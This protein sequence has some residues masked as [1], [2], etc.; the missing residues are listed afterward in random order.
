MTVETLQ[1]FN[2]IRTNEEALV[3]QMQSGDPLDR[4]SVLD[5]VWQVTQ[6]TRGLGQ[7]TFDE[8]ISSRGR[9]VY[10]PP[11]HEEMRQFELGLIEQL[12]SQDE[13]ERN[14]AEA[15]LSGFTAW[16]PGRIFVDTL[17]ALDDPDILVQ[18]EA[19]W[20]LS[21]IGIRVTVRAL[22][23]AIETRG[24][25]DPRIR[26]NIAYA[27]G[28]VHIPEAIE[29]LQTLLHD[30]NE[31]VR[32]A[33]LT[34]IGQLYAQFGGEAREEFGRVVMGPKEG[35]VQPDVVEGLQKSSA[36][37]QLQAAITIAEIQNPGVIEKLR[38]TIIHGELIPLQLQE[39][40]L[41]VGT[42]HADAARDQFQKLTKMLGGIV[43]ADEL[44]EM[45]DVGAIVDVGKGRLMRIHSMVAEVVHS[46]NRKFLESLDLPPTN[47]PILCAFTSNVDSLCFLDSQVAQKIIDQAIADAIEEGANLGRSQDD[48]IAEIL[49]IAHE[50]NP[51]NVPGK[52]STRAHVIGCVLRMFTHSGSKKSIVDREDSPGS[53][54]RLAEWIGQTFHPVRDK[55]G[56]ASAQMADFL[57]GIGEG[58]VAVY[59]QY[60]SPIQAAA[61]RNRRTKFFRQADGASFV[62]DFVSGESSVR[63]TDPTKIN[64]PIER[65]PGVKVSVNGDT[66]EAGEDADREIIT[67]DYYDQDGHAIDFEPLFFF[68]PPV[69]EEVGR[70]MRYFIINGPH[71]LQ[72]YKKDKYDR[73]APRLHT[74]LQTLQQEGVKIHF[75]FSG[76]T[77]R[78]TG[79]GEWT[80]IRYFKDVLRGTV[81][82]MGINHTELRDVVRS[83]HDDLDPAIE[84]T[85]EESPYALYR[86]AVALATYLGLDRLH[87]HGHSIDI[88]LRRNTSVEGLKKEQHATFHAKQRVGEWLLGQKSQYPTPKKR[89]QSPLLKR[90]GFVDLMKL[91]EQLA[92]A[93]GLEGVDKIRYMRDVAV[94]G[95]EFPK[96]EGYSAVIMPGKWIYVPVEVTTSAGDTISAAAFAQSGL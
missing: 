42:L 35:I 95:F 15:T 53:G 68:T 73:I 77:G 86:N 88:T 12:H 58:N 94:N 57:T 3:T 71:Y 5:I 41:G 85:A 54:K 24:K 90:E 20:A 40:I 61:Y 63:S 84:A 34:A 46:M 66:I 13:R 14:Y 16:I 67:T 9:E 4:L 49:R 36:P 79:A 10:I 92:E 19:A 87:V 23:Y 50:E 38:D 75:E 33:A 56:G 28:N 78:K 43:T 30:E 81:A 72:R 55:L 6:E 45:A 25:D 80:G 32:L 22:E 62:T 89:Q 64:F 44:Q 74:Q 76:D 96:A 7:E 2:T 8:I 93:S 21:G 27:L 29:P 47:I 60:H 59:T 18:M 70:Q 83:I 17:R 11:P 65:T 31:D 82:S 39:S 91:A 52:L 26:V 69:L 1:A 51:K 37:I 48:V